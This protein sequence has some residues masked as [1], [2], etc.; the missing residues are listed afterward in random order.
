MNS[1]RREPKIVEN[2][3]IG[4]GLQVP[5]GDGDSNLQQERATQSKVAVLVSGRSGWNNGKHPVSSREIRIRLGDVGEEETYRTR[6]EY[7]SQISVLSDP[8]QRIK[9][10]QVLATE[11]KGKSRTSLLV[12]TATH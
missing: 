3:S 2:K 6:N 5:H 7:W 4:C 8:H 9:R 10:I 11:L 1:T 12:K